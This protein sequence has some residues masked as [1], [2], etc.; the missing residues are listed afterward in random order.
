MIDDT[1]TTPPETPA[2]KRTSVSPKST[3]YYAGPII[4]D[5]VVVIC[6]TVGLILGAVPIDV[7]KYVIGALVVGNVALRIPGGR[8]NISNLPGGGGMVLALLGWFGKHQS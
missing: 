4:T 1:P 3:W 5:C 7:F 8:G 2:V 6:C